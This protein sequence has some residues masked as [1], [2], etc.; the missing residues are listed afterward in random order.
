MSNLISLSGFKGSG[1]DAVFKELPKM[2]PEYNFK[3]VAWAD[4]L[5]KEV[6]D[7]F[8]IDLK[9]LHADEETKNNT[10]TAIRWDR[11]WNHYAT[12]AGWSG[13]AQG[14]RPKYLTVREVLQLWGTDV[15]RSQDPNYWINKT[16]GL[17][18]SH[19]VSSGILVLTDTRFENEL[20]AVHKR[21]GTSIWICREQQDKTDSHVSEKSIADDCMFH[22]EGRGL[23]T[24]GETMRDTAGVLYAS[25]NNPFK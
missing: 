3:R 22:I 23:Q 8:G 1:K 18:D 25:R 13:L 20:E 2:F 19:P 12:L 9:L 6:S 4:P 10:V 11:F 24:L 7:I 17:I 14:G 16:I 21:Q 15:R 5:K